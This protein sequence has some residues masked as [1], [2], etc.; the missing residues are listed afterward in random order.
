[1]HTLSDQVKSISATLK[2]S[3]MVFEVA[4]LVQDYLTDVQESSKMR[5]SDDGSKETL[6]PASFYEKMLE[7][8]ERE[9]LK[10][11][12]ERLKMLRDLKELEQQRMTE[13]ELALAMDIEREIEAKKNLMALNRERRKKQNSV[14]DLGLILAETELESNMAAR[15]VMIQNPATRNTQTTI[16]Q[17]DNKS[18]FEAGKGHWLDNAANATATKVIL[19]RYQTD[20]EELEFLGRGGYGQVVKARNRIDGRLYALKKIR[21]D[22]RDQIQKLL[23]EVQALSRLFHKYVVRY[24]QAWFEHVEGEPGSRNTDFLSS[25]TGKD[26]SNT[27]SDLESTSNSLPLDGSSSNLLLDQGDWLQSG[28]NSKNLNYLDISFRYSGTPAQD[29]SVGQKGTS[30]THDS[31]LMLYIQMEYCEKKTLWDVIQAGIPLKESWR[32]FR[33]LLEGLNHIHKQGMIHRDLKPRNIF[34]DREGNI[35]IGDFGLAAVR[36]EPTSTAVTGTHSNPLLSASLTG[37]VGTPVYTAPEITSGLYK[38]YNYKV[39]IYSL[40]VCFFEV[41]RSFF[42]DKSPSTHSHK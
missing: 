21:V 7:R 9:E 19:S 15:P 18:S 42:V 3:E 23:R 36:D 4:N 35:K 34:L 31:H 27:D 10:T 16:V 30:S 1:M 24:Y 8:R 25:D 20:F 17:T 33:Q 22:P 38:S 32:L 11:E 40:G 26:S 14:D 6:Q 37:D 28:D 41:F 12:Q 5:E 29:V 39:D 13:Q 2:G